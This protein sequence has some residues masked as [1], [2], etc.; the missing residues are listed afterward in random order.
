MNEVLHIHSA[1]ESIFF[2]FSAEKHTDGNF[3]KSSS[4]EHDTFPVH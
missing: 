2:F 4:I 3:Y 1:R